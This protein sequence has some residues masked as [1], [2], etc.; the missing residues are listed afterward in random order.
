MGGR[1]SKQNAEA[2]PKAETSA[3]KQAKS[4]TTGQ[5][6]GSKPKAPQGRATKRKKYEIA[7]LAEQLDSISA[8]LKEQTQGTRGVGV[9]GR[10]FV[11]DLDTPSNPQSGTS[12]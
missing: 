11:Q 9:G 5:E 4:K 8:L 12:L 1:Q 7:D 6:G 10:P 3:S 2:Q